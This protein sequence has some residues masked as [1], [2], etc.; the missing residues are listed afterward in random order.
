MPPAHGL[1]ALAEATTVSPCNPVSLHPSPG[2]VL[3]AHLS[4]FLG[5]HSGVVLSINSREMHSYLVS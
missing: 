2:C 4:C 1:N 5:N 3:T